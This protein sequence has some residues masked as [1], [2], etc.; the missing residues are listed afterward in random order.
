VYARVK[1]AWVEGVAEPPRFLFRSKS[2]RQVSAFAQ[3]ARVPPA[4]ARRYR[5]ARGA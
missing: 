1:G 5:S 4:A 2:R 3:H